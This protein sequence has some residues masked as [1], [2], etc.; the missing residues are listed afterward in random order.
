MSRVGRCDA[1]SRDR[2]EGP[3]TTG[4]NIS[5]DGGLVGVVTEIDLL[6]D[7]ITADPRA[8]MHP[9]WPAPNG[10]TP[11]A[12]TVADVMTKRC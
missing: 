7:R 3:A 8:L 12:V 11:G 9:D 6:K 1:R 5:A 2:P 4:Q 10:N